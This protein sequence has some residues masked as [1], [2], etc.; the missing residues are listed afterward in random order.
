[1]ELVPTKASTIFNYKQKATIF[2]V[3]YKYPS[4]NIKN[5]TDNVEQ[6]RQKLQI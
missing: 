3:I 5:F 2:G 1:M 4:T 6:T